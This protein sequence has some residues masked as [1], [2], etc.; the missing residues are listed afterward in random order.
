MIWAHLGK[1]RGVQVLGFPPR[2]VGFYDVS[3]IEL[4]G[5]FF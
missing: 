4:L 2:I 1:F 5:L 3:T